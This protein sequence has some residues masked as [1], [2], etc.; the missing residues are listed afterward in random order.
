MFNVPHKP[1]RSVMTHQF[2]QVP[3]ADIPRSSFDRSHGYKTTFDAGYLVPFFVDEALPGDTFNVRMTG[4]SRLATPIFPIM[5]NMFMETQYFSIPM[6]LVW[7]NWQKFNGEQKIPAIQPISQFPKWFPQLEGMRSI[8]FRIIWGS[9][10]ESL[11]F[12]TPLSGI[13]HTI[14]FGTSGIATKTCR[15]PCLC[16]PET[17]LTFLQTMFY[18]VVVNDTTTSRLVYLGRKRA[19]A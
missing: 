16:P 3:K 18:N 10:P 5:D 7:D 9:L 1:S 17:G 2:S 8:R 15:I 6:R 12:P 14:W 19:L 4:F 11:G 13:A